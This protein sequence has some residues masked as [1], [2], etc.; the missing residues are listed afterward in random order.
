MNRER[1]KAWKEKKE[2]TAQKRRNATPLDQD[3][4]EA[5]NKHRRMKY[6][7]QLKKK[8]AQAATRAK[9]EAERA[10]KAE[11][12]AVRRRLERR[13]NLPDRLLSVLERQRAS[14]DLKVQSL[15]RGDPLFVVESD[16]TGELVV[17]FSLDHLPRLQPGRWFNQEII[18]WYICVFASKRPWCLSL[19]AESHR[20][21]L[22]PH[23]GPEFVA[24]FHRPPSLRGVGEGEGFCALEGTRVILAP[25]NPDGNHWVLVA[26]FPG[27]RRVCCYDSLSPGPK[28]S[29][30]CQTIVKGIMKW[31]ALQEERRS[32][33]M[34]GWRHEMVQ[35]LPRQKNTWDCGVHV[36]DFA[37]QLTMDPPGEHLLCTDEPATN[38]FRARLLVY[39]LETALISY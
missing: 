35:G 28:G 10:E 1:H 14:H 33:T 17:Q 19:G 23:Q 36:C 12:A 16:T 21:L 3:R 31:V 18:D 13:H 32:G 15:V 8:E 5:M 29:V 39:A 4:Q 2:T 7:E 11:R 38:T 25:A 22:I 9:L 34:D 30:A 27:Q 6:R 37:R 26:I 24:D 20:Q